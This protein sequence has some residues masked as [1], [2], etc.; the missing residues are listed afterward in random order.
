MRIKLTADSTIDLPKEILETHQISLSP[1]RINLEDTIYLDTINISVDDIYKAVAQGS[2]IPTTSAMNIWEYT[3]FFEQFKEYEQIIHF[4]LGSHFSSS[5]QNAYLA[6]QEVNN[7]S[8]IDTQNLSAGSGLLVLKA[9]KL[10]QSDMKVEDILSHLE[11]LIPKVNVSF[12]LDTLEYMRKGGRISSFAEYGVQTLKIHPSISVIDGEMK[13]GRLFHGSLPRSLKKY[14]TSIL[15]NKEKYEP[16]YLILA[17]SGLEDVELLE[18]IY[19]SIIEVNYFKSVIVSR[20]GS[21]IST[22]SGPNTVGL[23]GILK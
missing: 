8:V 20:V 17:H 6:A 18:S 12:V 2:S 1:L 16:D 23:L 21:T 11:Q 10:I 4:S 7:V 15:S 22:H 14:V 3:E 5:H 9:V 13:V 19:Q